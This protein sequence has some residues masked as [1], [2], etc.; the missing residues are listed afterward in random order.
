MSEVKVTKK[1]IQEARK[2]DVVLESATTLFDWLLARRTLVL[3]ALGGVVVLVGVVSLVQSQSA[4]SEQELG[5][6]LS[7]AVE[8]SGRPVIEHKDG[9]TVPPDDKSF[10]SKEAKQKATREAL[11]ALVASEPKSE[12]GKSAAVKLAQLDL[13]AGKTDEAIAGFQKYLSEN[14]AGGLQLF[15]LESLGY[16]YE[17]KNSLVEAADTFTRLGAAGAPGR[18]LYHKA[19]LAEKAGNKAE[20]KKLYAQVVS[21]YDKEVVAGDART[22]LELID[23]PPA[24]TGA[25][26]APPPVVPAVDKKGKK[27]APAKKTR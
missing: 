26:E 8:L 3:G 12:A 2:P 27:V 11:T 4:K 10:P 21:D 14:P 25:L 16:A 24:G 1:D 9:D 22:R 18:A 17:A 5:A 15:V 23:A 13:E 6:Q 19:R 20:A 7:K